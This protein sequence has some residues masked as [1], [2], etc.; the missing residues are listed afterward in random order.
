M[1]D[2]FIAISDLV[3]EQ[4]EIAGVSPNKIAVK[5]N[6]SPDPGKPGPIGT[7]FLFVGRLEIEKGIN[8]LLEAWGQ[9]GL[10]K[11]TT[12]TVAGDGAE[13]SAVQHAA[14]SDSSILF[15]GAVPAYR[16]GRLLDNCAVSIVPSLWLEAFPLATIESFARGRPVISVRSGSNEI[17]V[18]D[19]VGW[20]S[21]ATAPELAETMQRAFADTEGVRA[22]GAAA[23]KLYELAY[24]P[25][26]VVRSL[27]EIYMDLSHDEN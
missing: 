7:G 24:L 15:L 20:V 2:R 9:S 6:T 26:K 19:E 12:L 25:E 16:V 18:S 17:V 21:P 3:A 27:L 1:V 10:G 8:L 4:L 5:R 14:R 23:R 13:K 11:E 22:R